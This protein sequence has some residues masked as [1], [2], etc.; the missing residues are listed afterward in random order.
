MVTNDD[1]RFA[2][3]DEDSLV[4]ETAAKDAAV[5]VWADCQAK[6]ATV[7]KL[8]FHLNWMRICIATKDFTNVLQS[9]A[10][11]FSAGDQNEPSDEKSR[12]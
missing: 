9:H 3:V 10:L 11:V 8:L 2:V 1:S 5:V 6:D 12:A 7:T 4:F